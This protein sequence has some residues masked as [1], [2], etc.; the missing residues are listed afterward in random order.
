MIDLKK[1]F[2][3]ISWKIKG[4]SVYALVGESGTGKSFRAQLLAE[5]YGIKLIIDD[6]LLIYNDKIIAGQSAK[7]EK[8][9]LAAVKVALFDDKKHRDGAAKALQSHSFK[10]ILIL[11][12]S[13]KMVN[14]IAARLQIPQPQ[15]IIKI[16][17][18][19]SREEIETAMRSRRVEG[20]HVIPVPSLEVQRN[21]P[22]IFY[23][24]IRLF[25]KKKKTPFV[26]T[27][28]SKLFE[29]SV[30][31]PEFSKVGTV[32]ISESALSQMVFNCIQEYDKEVVIKK[33]NIKAFG[34]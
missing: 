15:K 24:K 7:R 5:K 2:K 28:Q 3:K 31:R 11:G 9:F 18:I 29:K 21:Y 33:L 12:T 30:V 32:E 4:V 6:G 16:E 10:K 13:E 20:K 14:K 22:K 1:L 34:G 17:D 26:G 27:E 23:D 8:T 19:A 25:F